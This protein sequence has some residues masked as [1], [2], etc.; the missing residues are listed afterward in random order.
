[1]K[2]KASF[3]LFD[4]MTSLVCLAPALAGALFYSQIPNQMAV[5]FTARGAADSYMDKN[6]FLFVIPLIAAVLQLSVCA[7]GVIRRKEFDGSRAVRLILPLLVYFA[8]YIVIGYSLN[9]LNN[10]AFIISAVFSFLFLFVGCFVP[11]IR[12]LPDLLFKIFPTLKSAGV[13]L[14]TLNAAGAMCMSAAALMMVLSFLGSLAAPFA[15]LILCLILPPVYS[16]AAYHSE[17][18]KT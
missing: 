14:K 8:Y 7:A 15:V 2:S 4:I 13:L 18:D 3:S 17:Y 11:K 9:V 1:M 16:V 12:V 6:I 10:P 5:H